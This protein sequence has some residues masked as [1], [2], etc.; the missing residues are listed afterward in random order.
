MEQLE[1]SIFDIIVNKSMVGSQS[2]NKG[3]DKILNE[4]S[5]NLILLI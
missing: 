1:C 2:I 5:L 3:E 4:T